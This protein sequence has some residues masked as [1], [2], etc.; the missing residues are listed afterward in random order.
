MNTAVP[1]RLEE[2][3]DR[4]SRTVGALL[5]GT[6]GAQEVICSLDFAAAEALA[7]VLEAG[8]HGDVAARLMHRW[9]VT[10]P[11]WD[12]EY[13]D[14]IRRWLALDVGSIPAR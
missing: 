3:V 2:A 8:R 10:E 13:G 12:E 9:A 7:E 5:G 4:L 1:P 14:V 11:D 6:P